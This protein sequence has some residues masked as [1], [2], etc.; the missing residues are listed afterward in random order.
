MDL[1]RD[2]LRRDGLSAVPGQAELALANNGRRANKRSL[3]PA[4]LPSS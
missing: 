4:F 2:G 3:L 1:G